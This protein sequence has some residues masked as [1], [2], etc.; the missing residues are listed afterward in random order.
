MASKDVEFEEVLP[1]RPYVVAAAL[2]LLVARFGLFPG[3]VEG[4][5]AIAD[6][7][8]EARGRE[9]EQRDHAQH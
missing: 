8:L 6:A 7:V 5:Y 9:G 1:L 4:A 2:K 3:V